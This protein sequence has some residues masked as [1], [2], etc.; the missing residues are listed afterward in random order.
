[1]KL[2]ITI[3]GALAIAQLA[4]PAQADPVVTKHTSVT[5]VH[6]PVRWLPHHK[7]KYCKIRRVG[8][9]RVKKCWYH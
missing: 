1:M 8:H 4:V 3:L 7:R 5:R 9:R 2:A 6:G